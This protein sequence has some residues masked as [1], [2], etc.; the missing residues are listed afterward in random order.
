[1]INVGAIV[2]GV[3]FWGCMVTRRLAEAG[4]KVLVLER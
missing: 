4:H 1:M 3:G 2:A